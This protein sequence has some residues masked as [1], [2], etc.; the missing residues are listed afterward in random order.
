VERPSDGVP[1]KLDGKEASREDPH[2]GT[3]TPGDGVRVREV[4]RGHEAHGQRREQ[5]ADD[6]VPVDAAAGAAWASMS[7]GPT[8]PTS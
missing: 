1:L 3:E 2:G 8:R 5:Q 7:R 4:E 6:E